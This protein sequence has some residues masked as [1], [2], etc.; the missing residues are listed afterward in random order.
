MHWD[1]DLSIF[2]E[3]LH[4]ANKNLTWVPWT[5]CSQAY[6][7]EN[8][9]TEQTFKG[10][11]KKCTWCSL[12]LNKARPALQTLPQA[13]GGWLGWS[14]AHQRYDPMKAPWSTSLY[15]LNNK[16]SKYLYTQTKQTLGEW[17]LNCHKYSHKHI[18][19]CVYK[20]TN[21]NMHVYTYIYIYTCMC[22]YIYVY[23]IVKVK[24]S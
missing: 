13:E 1:P 6:Q 9:S 24:S 14:T 11:A 8:T 22:I 2:P 3:E 5:V 17:L 15:K 4:I 20:H 18:P 21:M 12:S 7:A 23:I 10:M 19:T 16:P